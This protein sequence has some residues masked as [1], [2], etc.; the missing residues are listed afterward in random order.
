MEGRWPKLVSSLCTFTSGW[1]FKI[2]ISVWHLLRL[3]TICLC[4]M[5]SYEKHSSYFQLQFA[6]LH[7]LQAISSDINSGL[8]K[9]D[10]CSCDVL[11][12]LLVSKPASYTSAVI[13]KR[14]MFPI[15]RWVSSKNVSQNVSWKVDKKAMI[16]NRYNRIPYPALNTKRERDTYN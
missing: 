5:E 4:I 2:K 1:T 6:I 3:F 10:G 14:R 8:K 9:P 11:I 12:S 16:T 13:F 7:Q 15:N